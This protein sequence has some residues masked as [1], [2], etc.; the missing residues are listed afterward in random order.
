VSIIVATWN[1]E[2]HIGDCLQSI[3]R[4]ESFADTFEILVV[5][6]NSSDRT[7]EI[8]GEVALEHP[9]VRLL[10]NPERFAPQAFNIGIRESRG[11]WLFVLGA[12]SRYDPSYFRRCLE[13]ARRTGADNTGGIVV[14][15][16]LQDDLASRV[17]RAMGASPFGFG[18]AA[19]RSRNARQGPASTAAF[20][21]FPRRTFERFG[22]YDERLV[23]NQDWELNQRIRR[24][25][26]TVWLDPDIRV[27]YF[28]RQTMARMASRAW[29]T[30]KW[31]AYMW[32]LGPHV[33]SPRHALP[34]T[35]AATLALPGLGIAALLAH[36]AA[37]VVASAAE[38]VRFR[39]GRLVAALPP[40][41]LAVHAAYGLGTLRGIW[42]VMTRRS[43][44]S[45]PLP[46]HLLPPR[47][48]GAH[49]DGP[50]STVG[51]PGKR[52]GRRS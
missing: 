6:G 41:F 15:C 44:V 22:L 29:D 25:G 42:D 51:T 19:F 36:Q 46:A 30:G 47:R 1:E 33:V 21:C 45:G 23:L 4:A 50:E 13:T 5:D 2:A 8:V 37:A 16:T 3:Y 14:T 31:V 17:A 35:F 40:A 34:A 7:R 10:H 24:E 27:Y 38:A 32:T 20:G 43:P 18:S 48:R 9:E 52:Q 39:D 11:N 12:H 28:A 49:V 26:G